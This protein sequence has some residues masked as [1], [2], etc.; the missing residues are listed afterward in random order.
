MLANFNK[1]LFA[2]KLKEYKGTKSQNDIADELDIKKPTLS[3][4]ENG[5]QLPTIEMLTKVCLYLNMSIDSFFIK[6]EQ[7]SIPLMRRQLGDSDKLKLNNVMERIKIRE[8]YIAINRRC[9]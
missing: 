1:E 4:L 5:K 3:L 6:E 9:N 2:Q 8:K 7:N